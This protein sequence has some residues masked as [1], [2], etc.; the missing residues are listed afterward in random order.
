MILLGGISRPADLQ[1]T[2]TRSPPVTGRRIP[3]PPRDVANCEAVPV[4]CLFCAS[5]AD[6]PPIMHLRRSLR[7]ASPRRVVATVLLG[8]LPLFWPLPAAVRRVPRGHRA[9]AS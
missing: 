6:S 5:C 1:Y 3:V 2:F 8:V 4:T 9:V 7:I